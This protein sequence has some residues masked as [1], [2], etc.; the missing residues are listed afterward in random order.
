ME[1][2]ITD[3]FNSELHYDVSCSQAT[4]GAFAGDG[5]FNLAKES[6][7]EFNLLDTKEKRSAAIEFFDGFGAWG[8]EEMEN[9]EHNELNA[10][11]LQLIS[12]DVNEY[13]DLAADNWDWAEYEELSKEGV[14]NGNLFKGVDS[15]IY[16]YV[17]D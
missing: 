1:I 4:H 8:R 6:S 7:N 10:L 17:G 9:W 14:V 5:S 12:G 13:Q 11:L 2:N 15:E 3:Y 16:Y